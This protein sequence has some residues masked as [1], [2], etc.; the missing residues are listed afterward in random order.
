MEM[1]Q[2]TGGSLRSFDFMEGTPNS[3]GESL[4]ELR[5]DGATGI[6]TRIL[7]GA[8]ESIQGV[9]DFSKSPRLKLE[10]F[11]A[12]VQ[13]KKLSLRCQVGFPASSET[14]PSWTLTL[15]KRDSVPRLLWDQ[16]SDLFELMAIPSLGNPDLRNGFKDFLTELVPILDL[17]R[18]PEGPLSGISLDMGVY[19][20]SLNG[21][22][23]GS[24]VDFLQGRYQTIADLNLLY[25]TSFKSFQSV[26]SLQGIRTMLD[27]RPWLA[28]YDYKWC[29][30]LSMARYSEEFLSAMP[31]DRTGDS[32]DRISDMSTAP[33]QILLDGV[34]I[35]ESPM[36]RFP[37]VVG[38]NV[39]PQTVLAYRFFRYVEERARH[40]ALPLTLL[41]FCQPQLSLSAP[42]A[43]LL[44]G[45]Y[46]ARGHFQQIHRYVEQ[47]GE[48]FFPLGQPLYDES[49]NGYEWE[50]NREKRLVEFDGRRFQEMTV[51]TGRAWVPLV[52]LPYAADFWSEL[53]G[54]FSRLGWPTRGD[55]HAG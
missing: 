43:V 5:E 52:S 28:A 12:L 38:G 55:N 35:G 49:L 14:F 1:S 18:K 44:C 24:F 32:H 33:I 48:I 17:Y 54:N 7:W 10:K 20:G 22:E 37:L 19:W 29:L 45:K 3:W 26:T 39:H 53:Q 34:P 9:R 47:G 6:E 4:D 25:G 13:E 30:R 40:Q 46:L 23:D 2:S 42:R 8:H 51:G 16:R 15:P 36:G 50:W 11:L 27:K 41:S 31:S 21:T